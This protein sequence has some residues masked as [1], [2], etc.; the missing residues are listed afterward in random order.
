M[1]TDAISDKEKMEEK[2]IWERKSFIRLLIG[3]VIFEM[4]MRNPNED[5]R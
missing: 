1:N 3:H 4:S 2:Q 5:V